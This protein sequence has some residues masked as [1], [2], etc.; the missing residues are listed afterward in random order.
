M[1]FIENRNNQIRK[2]KLDN[3]FNKLVFA[4]TIFKVVGENQ[5]IELLKA[6]ATVVMNRFLYEYEID[7]EMTFVKCITNVDLFPCWKNLKSMDEIDLQNC[8]FKK[9]FSL[10]LKM[11]N[12]KVEDNTLSSIKFKKVSECPVWA[13]GL[14]YVK[15]IDDYLFYNNCD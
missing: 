7:D 1:A 10:A 12:G 3:N 14:K 6:V 13:V 9:C 5:N 8:F 15:A 11:L 2:M 4:K